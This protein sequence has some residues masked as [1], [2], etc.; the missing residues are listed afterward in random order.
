MLQIVANMSSLFHISPSWRKALDKFASFKLQLSYHRFKVDQLISRTLKI[1]NELF[2]K[3]SLP[4]MCQLH[5]T[6]MSLHYSTVTNLGCIRKDC[7]ASFAF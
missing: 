2:G 1:C 7:L 4:F 3:A 5:A 6:Q